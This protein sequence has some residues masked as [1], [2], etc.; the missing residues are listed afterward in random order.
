MQEPRG[1]R[2]LISKRN[3][4]AR[5][6]DLSAILMEVEFY[7]AQV[8]TE[9]NWGSVYSKLDLLAH[10]LHNHGSALASLFLINKVGIMIL[11]LQGRQEVNK[12]KICKALSR[13]WHIKLNKIMFSENSEPPLSGPVYLPLLQTV[14]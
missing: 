1:Q 6:L 8:S 5:S 14:L 11:N 13:A 3:E 12:I 9:M 7:R 2:L 10:W 4:K